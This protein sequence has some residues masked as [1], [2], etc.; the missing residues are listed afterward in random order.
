M[1]PPTLPTAV[2]PVVYGHATTYSVD[3]DQDGLG[4]AGTPKYAFAENDS[5]LMVMGHRA[6]GGPWHGGGLRC[7]LH[8]Q[9]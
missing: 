3:V 6:A 5:R 2:S 1:P 7:G 9:L 8:V 4:G